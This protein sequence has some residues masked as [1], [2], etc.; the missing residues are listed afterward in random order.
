MLYKELLSCMHLRININ[1]FLSGKIIFD[2]T[3]ISFDISREDV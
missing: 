2:T 1:Y 3:Y